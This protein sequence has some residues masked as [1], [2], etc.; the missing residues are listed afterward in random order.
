ME[1]KIYEQTI[2]GGS[3]Q[4]LRH[5]K[6]LHS[7]R[8]EYS[9]IHKKCVRKF[10][11][12]STLRKHIRQC[13]YYRDIKND[14]TKLNRNKIASNSSEKIFDFPQSHT[15]KEYFYEDEIV[16]SDESINDCILK[17]IGN[18]YS[19][20]TITNVTIQKITDQM[21]ET[22]NDVLLLLK[23]KLQAVLPKQFHD[24][25]NSCCNID[26]LKNFKTE[27][28]QIQYF[29]KCKYLI[30]SES[31]IIGE[32]GNDKVC[33]E[34]GNTVLEIKKCEGQI[35]PMRQALKL[36]MELSNVYEI[37]TTYIDKESSCTDGN[38]SNLFHGS[39]WKNLKCN[40]KDKIVIPLLLYYDDFETGN[41]L[42]PSAGIH[43]VGAM[44][45][46]IAAMPPMYSST[47]HNIHLVQLIYNSD[48]TRF[49]NDKC[50][51]NVIEE[52]KFLGEKIIVYISQ[53]LH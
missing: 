2:L 5:V 40:Y 18:L 7:L 37:V 6:C 16:Q 9:C 46:S 30:P 44:Y 20:P 49:G 32:M 22:V 33:K 12:I 45:Y 10:F 25:I 8:S 52:L 21:T 42:S 29:E 34:T 17:F 31:F 51:N 15:S 23:S 13:M 11:T 24:E 50:F 3:E 41:P 28:K 4:L 26:F 48:R 27:Y 35:I 38:F 53:S 36:Y 47:L 14:M 19:D 43:K 1:C 39:L